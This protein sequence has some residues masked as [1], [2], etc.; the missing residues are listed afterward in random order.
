MA[1]AVNL[2]A[3]AGA[4]SPT[5]TGSN[6]ACTDRSPYRILCTATDRRHWVQR[7]ASGNRGTHSHSRWRTAV[8]EE[9]PDCWGQPEQKLPPILTHWPVLVERPKGGGHGRSCAPGSSPRQRPGTRLPGRAPAGW[10]RPP[11]GN[12]TDA[13][14]TR[15]CRGSD[16]TN[17]SRPTAASTRGGETERSRG[18]DPAGSSARIEPPLR[19]S[20]ACWVRMRATS[21]RSQPSTPIA[22]RLVA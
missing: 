6:A 18:R 17:T 12:A 19:R 2:A 13:S 22:S 3:G 7:R 21:P 16:R 1:R 8:L 14:R 4:P 20:T 10:S 11:P 9:R 5:A 15:A